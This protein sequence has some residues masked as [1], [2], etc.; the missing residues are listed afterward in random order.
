MAKIT[1]EM[2]SSK[3]AYILKENSPVRTKPLGRI[4]DSPYPGNLRNNGIVLVFL[5]KENA[6]III[7]GAPAP[8]AKYTETTSHKPGW[9]NKSIKQFNSHLRALGGIFK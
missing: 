9:R 4:K 7:G 1:T 8:Y 2:L 5:N 6:S 3:L